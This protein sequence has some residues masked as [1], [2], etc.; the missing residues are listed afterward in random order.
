MPRKSICDGQTYFH[1]TESVIILKDDYNEIMK[2]GWGPTTN[3]GI[4]INLNTIIIAFK[5][6]CLKT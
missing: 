1:H 3:R 4:G 2:D 6:M 5:K